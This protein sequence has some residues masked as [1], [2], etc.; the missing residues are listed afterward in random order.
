MTKKTRFEEK[1]EKLPELTVSVMASSRYPYRLE[2]MK[3]NIE[4]WLW[5][6][7][8]RPVKFW[9]QRRTRGW[10]DSELWSLDA[11]IAKFVR[12]RLA[13][14]KEIKHGY[15]CDLTEQE[16]DIVVDKMLWSLDHVQDEDCHLPADAHLTSRELGIVCTWMPGRAED[17]TEEEK[18]TA[19]AK[20]KLYRE[21]TEQNQARCQEGLDLFGKY[22]RNLWD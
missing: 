8:Q 14:L 18:S 7:I 1:V 10:D 19:Q 16:W 20:W 4:T 15:P 2:L 13:R 22:F 11:T 21:V 12:P 5:C 9:W 17:A 3:D 6:Y